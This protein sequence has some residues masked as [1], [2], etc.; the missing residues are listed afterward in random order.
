MSE[1]IDFKFNKPVVLTLAFA[2]RR[3]RGGRDDIFV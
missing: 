3:R 2:G 1:T